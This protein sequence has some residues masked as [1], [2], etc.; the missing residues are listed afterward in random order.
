LV[1]AG[2][3]AAPK[4]GCMVGF[5]AMNGGADQLFV[6]G[7]EVLW[8]VLSCQGLKAV[9][10]SMA[11]KMWTSSGASPRCSTIDRIRC[12]LRKFFFLTNSISSPCSLAT[13]SAW[14]RNSSRNTS[15]HLG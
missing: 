2:G 9:H 15:A 4:G 10:D 13:D 6:D 3:F 8:V 5:N 14:S 12:S 1:G 7:R 11:E